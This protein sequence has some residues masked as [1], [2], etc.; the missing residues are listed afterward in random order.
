MGGLHQ[1][2]AQQLRAIEPYREYIDSDP[3]VA[4]MFRTEVAG[5]IEDL[6]PLLC[7]ALILTEVG[8]SERESFDALPY[9]AMISL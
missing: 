6:Q 1:G 5:L 2:L 3:V 9:R 7:A 8:L 4:E